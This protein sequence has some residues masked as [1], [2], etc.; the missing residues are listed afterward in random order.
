M[1]LCSVSGTT[2]R[3]SWHNGRIGTRIDTHLSLVSHVAHP[4]PV[5]SRLRS[6]GFSCMGLLPW[7]WLASHMAASPETDKPVVI[8]GAGVAGLTAAAVR[9]RA[10]AAE[11]TAAME[12]TEKAHRIEHGIRIVIIS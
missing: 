5:F 6:P 3:P 8:V 11:W 9:G 7:V 1:E 10:G 12:G 4:I 2:G